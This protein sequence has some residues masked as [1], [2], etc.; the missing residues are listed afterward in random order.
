M[1]LA[2]DRNKNVTFIP[3]A[4]TI[5]KLGEETNKKVKLTFPRRLLRPNYKVV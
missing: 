5:S 4:L 2:R 1:V 3:K